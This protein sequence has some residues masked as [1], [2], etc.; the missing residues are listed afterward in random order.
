MN[1]IAMNVKVEPNGQM[2]LSNERTTVTIHPDGTIAVSSLD[3]VQLTGACAAKLDHA[4]P[5]SDMIASVLQ[6]LERRYDKK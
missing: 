2:T 6:A 5:S 1:G 3:P 4:L